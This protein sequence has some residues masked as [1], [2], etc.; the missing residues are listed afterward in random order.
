MIGKNSIWEKDSINQF[1]ESVKY[2]STLG[3]LHFLMYVNVKNV[4]DK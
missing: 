1:I 2:F 4:G 3:N